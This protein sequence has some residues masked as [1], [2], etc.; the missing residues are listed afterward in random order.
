MWFCQAEFEIATKP[1]SL[2]MRVKRGWEDDG[3][4]GG[5]WNNR[6]TMG[7]QEDRRT[8][9]WEHRNMGTQEDGNTGTQEHRNTGTQE[10]RNTGTQEHRNTGG[11]EHG[12][13]DTGHRKWDN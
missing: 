12:T 3:R 2:L 6:R 9:T 10:H 4:M 13:W 11:W 7:G 1:L 5:K 8:G